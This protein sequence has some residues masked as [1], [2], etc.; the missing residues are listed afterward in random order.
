MR[1]GRRASSN[2]DVWQFLVDGAPADFSVRARIH[3]NNGDVLVQAAARGMGIGYQPDF[4]VDDSIMTGLVK[5]IL[6]AYSAPELGV[7][8]LL[9]S[10]RQIPYRVRVLID[11]IAN[12][13]LQRPADDPLTTVPHLSRR[14]S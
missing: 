7:Y 12:R 14:A 5:P 10:N 11:F 9:P 3:S 4:I 13:L 6:T 8:V 2:F 1:E